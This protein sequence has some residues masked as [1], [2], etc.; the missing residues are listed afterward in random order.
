MNAV[1][2]PRAA[3]WIEK[4]AWALMLFALPLT[5]FPY[6]P[7]AIGGEALVR[8]LSLYPLIVLLPF[9]VLPR[10]CANA[11][12][13]T[14]LHLQPLSWLPSV[15][16]FS[17]YCVG[18]ASLGYFCRIQSFTRDIHFR[19]GCAFFTAVPIL[20][21][22]PEDLRFSLRWIYAGVSTRC[23][24]ERFKLTIFFLQP[25]N[26]SAGYRGSRAVYQSAA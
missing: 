23:S 5:S 22:T 7:R 24:G 13:R 15:S 11:C 25:R 4:A 16:H 10:L 17:L 9:S 20:P 19:I 26:T 18:R 3:R 21:E 12:R 1:S 2:I 8:P 6:F 14:F